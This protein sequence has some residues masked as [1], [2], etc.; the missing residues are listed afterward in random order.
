[1]RL[2]AGLSILPVILGFYGIIF[3]YYKKVFIENRD[4]YA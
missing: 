1:M 3:D 4:T 2:Y